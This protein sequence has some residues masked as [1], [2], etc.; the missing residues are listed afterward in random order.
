MHNEKKKT[1]FI[2]FDL[3]FKEKLHSVWSLA[4][5]PSYWEKS[6]PG[7]MFDVLSLLEVPLNPEPDGA[8]PHWCTCRYCWEMDSG[9]SCSIIQTFWLEKYL[10]WILKKMQVTMLHGLFFALWLLCS[11]L[12]RVLWIK[13]SS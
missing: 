5:R 13:V 6:S 9:I 2:F 3:F 11:I 12:L 1:I 4:R 7:M 8:L 10:F